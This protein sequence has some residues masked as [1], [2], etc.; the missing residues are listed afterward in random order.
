MVTIPWADKSDT[1][2]SLETALSHI[3]ME[4]MVH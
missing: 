1:Q 3:A 2:I 4:D